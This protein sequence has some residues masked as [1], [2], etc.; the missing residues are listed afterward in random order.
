MSKSVSGSRCRF[1][2]A[3]LSHSFVNLGV[4]PLCQTHVGPEQL[5]AM[6]PFYPLHALV[7]TECLLVQLDEYVA[8]DDIFTEYAYFSSYSDSWLRHAADYC[9]KITDRR[10]LGTDSLVVELASKDGYLLRNFVAAGI[11]CLGIEPAQNVAE[12]AQA[13]GIRMVTEFF[14]EA[15]ARQVRSDY[16]AADLIVGNNVLAHV[17][18]LNDFVAGIA[19]LLAPSG[20]VTMEFPHLLRLMDETQFDTIYHEH[21]S[22]FSFLTVT[23]VFRRHGMVIFDVEELATHGGSLRIY[24]AHKGQEEIC[25]TVGRLQKVER[26]AGLDSLE[27]YS[28]FQ[29]RVNAVK[30]DLLAFLIDAKRNGNQVVGYGAPGKGNTLLNYCGIGPDF[31]DYTVDRNPYKQGKYT[32]GSRIPIV[33]PERIVETRPDYVLILPWNL[34]EEIVSS[35]SNVAEW[36]GRFVVPIPRLELIDPR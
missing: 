10:Q 29:P 28:D 9:A 11:P 20:A 27:A 25:A 22:Y 21:F 17:P 13:S 12:V 23:E 14:G 8:P 7:C 15:T 35:N 16:G 31:L 3:P 34:R 1:C 5:D 4:T 36:G 19:A 24:A 33:A 2:A 18:D 32:P 30:R 6:E 26:E